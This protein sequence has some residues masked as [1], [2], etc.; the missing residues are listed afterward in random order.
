MRTAGSIFLLIILVPASIVV[1]FVFS[2]KNNVLTSAFLKQEL[3]RQH[4]YALAEDQLAQQI[5]KI[6]LEG[7]PIDTT[8]LQELAAQVLS[9]SWLQ[10]N[11]ERTLDRAFAWFN[12]PSGTQLSLPIDLTDPKAA[13]IPGID[14]LITAAIP[15]LPECTRKNEGELCR[16]PGMTTADLKAS[17]Q[18]Q[19]IDLAAITNQ[20]PDTIDL[21]NPVLP[22]IQLGS[23]SQQI[24]NQQTTNK[25]RQPAESEEQKSQ[26]EEQEI[27]TLQAQPEEHNDDSKQSVQD[28][29]K[30]L[31]Q[32]KERYHMALRIWTSA[33][34][35]YAVLV[36][37][38]LAINF[39]D[40]H[41]LTRWAGIL[42]LSIGV[43]P[44]AISSASGW[45][46]EHELLPKIM[47]EN[48]PPD[49][50]TAVPSLIRDTQSALFGPVLI[51]SAVLLVLGLAGIIGARWVPQREKKKA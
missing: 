2:L 26:S 30:N 46:M 39:K 13:L 16:I 1:F 38:F 7:V 31:E 28:V 34:I 50:Q 21:A 5:A 51:F 47:L 6:K 45:I 8:D 43:L 17:L 10:A 3:V 24:N 11:V 29:V 44:L 9:A 27:Q 32:A 42:F 48:V 33:L 25:E 49:V 41:R 15:K 18:Q 22:K 23:N 37:L 19:G 36:L 14:T 40:W 35:G 12:S 4:V 20:L